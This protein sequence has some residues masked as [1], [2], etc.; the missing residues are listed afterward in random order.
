MTVSLQVLSCF[1][2][3]QG[4]GQTDD[5]RMVKKS[6]GAGSCSVFHAVDQVTIVVGYAGGSLLVI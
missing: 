1:S 4:A 2:V 5:W 3:S 6:A